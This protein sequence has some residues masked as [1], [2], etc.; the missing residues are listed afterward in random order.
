M[1]TPYIMRDILVRDANERSSGIS[2]GGINGHLC[3]RDGRVAPVGS[4]HM[5]IKETREP[6]IARRKGSRDRRCIGDDEETHSD[7]PNHVEPK[8]PVEVTI[9]II[10]QM[11]G[12][13]EGPSTSYY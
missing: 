4:N 2:I 10:M 8:A 9:M 1:V 12:S 11:R 6:H 5:R 3:T 13:K 7:M